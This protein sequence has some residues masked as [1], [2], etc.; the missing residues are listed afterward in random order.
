MNQA[1]HRLYAGVAKR[2]LERIIRLP[3]VFKWVCPTKLSSWFSRPC[4]KLSPAHEGLFVMHPVRFA[5]VFYTLVVSQ[6]F[7]VTTSPAQSVFEGPVNGAASQMGIS[8]TRPDSGP[9]VEVED[10]FMV[11]YTL[12]IPGSKVAIEMIPVPG[13]KFQMGSEEAEDQMP[14]VEVEVGPMW[15]AKCETTWGEYNLYMSMYAL[16][17][18]LESKGLRKVD[19]SNEV[20]AVTA[21]TELYEPSFTFQYGQDANLPAVTMTQFAAKQYT[22]WLTKLTGHQYRLPTEAEWEYACRAGSTTA[23]H[24]GDDEAELEEY[25]W[26]SENSQDRPHPVGKKKPNNFGLHDMHGNVMEWAVDGYSEE[27]YAAIAD[28]PQPMSFL[29]SVRWPDDAE[30]RVVRG[31]SWQDEAAQLRSAARIGS[32]DEDWK[33]EDPNVPL[34]PWWFTDDPTRGIGFRIFRSYQPL[35]EA[36]MKRFWEIDHEDIE[37]DVDSRISRGRGIRSAVDPSLAKDIEAAGK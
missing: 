22:K 18:Q 30:N 12:V 3:T 13:G 2:S 4:P 27:G 25:A 7:F 16:F 6:L 31:G 10:G 37:F 29:A 9:S 33:A 8:P 34:S 32:Q 24:F 20:D 36:T 23:Y 26:Y 19:E 21:P 15:V 1:I 28:N 11:P 14:T 17:K 5:A 35:D